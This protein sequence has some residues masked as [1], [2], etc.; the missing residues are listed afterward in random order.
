[1]DK[2]PVF[3]LVLYF[4]PMDSLEPASSMPSSHPSSNSPGICS[5]DN[6]DDMNSADSE[7]QFPWKQRE[8]L[9]FDIPVHDSERAGL[10]VSVKGKTSTSRGKFCCKKVIFRKM[11]VLW[12]YRFKQYYI[13]KYSFLSVLSWFMTLNELVWVFIQG[14]NFNQKRYILQ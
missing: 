7:F 4:Q 5:S 8:I 3:S 13:N 12:Y 14:E 11:W 9:T 6:Y 1:M 2:S 10:G